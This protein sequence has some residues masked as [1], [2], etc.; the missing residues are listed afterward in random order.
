MRETFACCLKNIYKFLQLCE[1]K[2]YAPFVSSVSVFQLFYA[3]YNVMVVVVKK[4]KKKKTSDYSNTYQT[5]VFISIYVYKNNDE[6]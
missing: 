3:R 5:S 4:K 2:L 1:Q 6:Y